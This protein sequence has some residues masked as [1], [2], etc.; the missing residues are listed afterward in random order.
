MQA[1]LTEAQKRVL[2]KSS[3]ELDNRDKAVLCKG[4]RFAPTPNWRRLV[5]Y[6]DLLNAHQHV[7]RAE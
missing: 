2:N 1:V 6:A 4:L 3:I 7:R 5:E